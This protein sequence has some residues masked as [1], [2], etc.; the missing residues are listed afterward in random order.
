LDDFERKSPSVPGHPLQHDRPR[1]RPVVDDRHLGLAPDGD[2]GR[3]G[4]DGDHAPADNVPR[5][6]TALTGTFSH[7]R[8]QEGR[9]VISVGFGHGY[10]PLWRATRIDATQTMSLAPLVG[11]AIAPGWPRS[12]VPATFADMMADTHCINSVALGLEPEEQ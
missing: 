5:G 7:A 10:V 3:R 1:A 2:E 8:C 12:P 6:D 4:A 11:T 9:E